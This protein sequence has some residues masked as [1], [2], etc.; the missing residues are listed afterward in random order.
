MDQRPTYRS[1]R[2][3]HDLKHHI[4]ELKNGSREH[5]IFIVGF[6]KIRGLFLLFTRECRFFAVQF[7]YKLMVLSR[8]V[9]GLDPLKP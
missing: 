5:T 9:E 1:I 6:L 2:W 3:Y 8:K 7:I 4:D